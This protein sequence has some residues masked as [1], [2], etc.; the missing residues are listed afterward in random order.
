MATKSHLRGGATVSDI[1]SSGPDRQSQQ[2]SRVHARIFPAF[3]FLNIVV[4]QNVGTRDLEGVPW[5][6]RMRNRFP[7]VFSGCFVWK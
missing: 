4:V 3:F 6:A 5:G 1:T 2:W 7:A